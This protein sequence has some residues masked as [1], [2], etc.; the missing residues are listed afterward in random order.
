MGRITD[1]GGRMKIREFAFLLHF[2]PFL[3][4][5]RHAP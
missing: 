2:S 3:L 5:E 4:P 1:D